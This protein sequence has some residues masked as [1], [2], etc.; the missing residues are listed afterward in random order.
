MLSLTPIIGT[1]FKLRGW[2]CVILAFFCIYAGIQLTHAVNYD[3]SSNAAYPVYHFKSAEQLV[4][5]GLSMSAILAI[6][7]YIRPLISDILFWWK[8]LKTDD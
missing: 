5:L 1:T 3:F 6:A 4:S 2:Q 7:M 8:R